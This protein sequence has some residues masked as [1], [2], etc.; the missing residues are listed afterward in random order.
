MKILVVEDNEINMEIAEFYLTEA[1]AKTEKAWNGAEA[2]QKFA[3]SEAGSFDVILMDVMMPVMDG[4]EATRRIRA[5]EHPDAGTVTILAMTAQSS[6]DSIRQCEQAGM[7]GYIA[8]PVE[9]AELLRILAE[10]V[11]KGYKR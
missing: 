10:N 9:A 6:A 8:K 1:G 4:L 7:N 5:L 2:V 11:P 3:E